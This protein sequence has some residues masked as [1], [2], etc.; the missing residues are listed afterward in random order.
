M[1]KDTNDLF[2]ELGI[3]C[4]IDDYLDQNTSSFVFYKINE[5]WENACTNGND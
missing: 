1:K 4:K 2:E 3:D 5:F